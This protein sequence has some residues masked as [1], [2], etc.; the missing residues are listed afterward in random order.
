[1]KRAALPL[2]LLLS[3][4]DPNV[5]MR[6]YVDVP[7]PDGQV[8]KVHMVCRRI[9]DS[10][11]SSLS[12]TGVTLPL[13]SV[14]K[15][16]IGGI[17]MVSTTAA[18][19]DQIRGMDL[20]QIALCESIIL[21]PVQAHLRQ[22]FK[23]YIGIDGY[24]TQQIRVLNS[25]TTPQQYQNAADELIAQPAVVAPSTAVA[26]Q[27]IALA[28]GAVASLQAPPLQTFPKQPSLSQSVGS[29]GATPRT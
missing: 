25:S 1:M 13:T 20:Q 6:G 27:S 23:D 15:P 2:L 24:L 9:Y 26:V 22:A 16:Q 7:E 21:D 17:S 4:C 29:P 12:I 10:A 5:L 8:Q 14:I 3:A 19:T 28:H 18:G 11:S